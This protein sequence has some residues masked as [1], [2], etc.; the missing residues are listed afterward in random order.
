MVGCPAC[1][2]LLP[3]SFPLA[4]TGG[5]GHN[6]I[7]FSLAPATQAPR[8]ETLFPEYVPVAGASSLPAF[9]WWSRR[10]RSEFHPHFAIF[11]RLYQLYLSHS[12]LNSSSW[13]PP[14]CSLQTHKAVAAVSISSWFG[15]GAAASGGFSVISWSMPAAPKAC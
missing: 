11:I 1:L 10:F 15:H 6:S 14:Y 4:G 8:Q 12:R 3:L 13:P 2:S 5:P 9:R 7:R